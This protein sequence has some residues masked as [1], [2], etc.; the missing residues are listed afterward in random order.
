MDTAATLNKL[1]SKIEMKLPRLVNI[2][3]IILIAFTLAKLVWGLFD[4]GIEAPAVFPSVVSANAIKPQPRQQFDRKVAQ[5]HVMGKAA[6]AGAKKVENAPDTTLNLKLLGVLAGD[7]EYGY[8]IISSGGTK[9]KHYALGDD[10]PGGATLHAVYP[11]RVILER[12]IRMETLRLPKSQAAGFGKKLT[13]PTSQPQASA[14]ADSFDS[15]EQFR[16]E[17]MKNPLRL[18]EF[19]NAALEKDSETGEYIGYKLSPSKNPDMFYQFGFQPGDIV[20]NINGVPLDH[21]D[22]GPKAIQTLVNA[23][24]ITIVVLREGTEITL[25]QDLSQ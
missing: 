4:S 9:I 18:T 24:E 20:T 6:P 7:K 13:N 2:A 23:T 12:D 8:A 15:L 22:K 14:Q 1:W 21:P 10:I 19:I 3:L 5:L 17:I 16:Q 11:D 25:F